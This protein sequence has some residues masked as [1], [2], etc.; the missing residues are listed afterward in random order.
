VMV[1]REHGGLSIALGNGVGRIL[2]TLQV[3]LRT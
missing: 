1:Y 2:D 3:L